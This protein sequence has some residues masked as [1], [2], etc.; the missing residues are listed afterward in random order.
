MKKTN[1]L[2]LTLIVAFACG[3]EIRAAAESP[4]QSPVAAV[5]AFLAKPAAERGELADQPFAKQPLSRADAEAIRA[6][7]TRDHAEQIRATR[8][9]EVADRKLKI[10]DLEMPFTLKTFGE[11]P[12]G[13]RSLYIS[14]H[15]G[16]NAPARVN[17]RQWS[18]Q[19]KLYEL[20]EGVYIAPRAPTNTWNLWHE[21]HVDQFFDRLIEDLIVLEEVDPNRVYL[22]GYSAGGDGVFQLAPRMADRLAAASMMAGHPNETQ[23]QG[24][25]NIGFALFMGGKDSAYGRND[26]AREWEKKLADLKAA[27]PTGYKHFVKIFPDKGHW[28]DREDAIG[29]PWMAKLTRNPLPQKVVWRQDDV[30]HGRFYWLAVDDDQRRP[31]SLVT[32]TVDGQRIDLTAENVDKL[33]VRLADGLV[34]LDQPVKITAGERVLFE[35]VV[36]RTAATLTKTLAERG[37]PASVFAGEVEVTGVAAP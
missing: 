14:M 5:E 23:P 19:Q 4:E 2:S 17:D 34:D 29:I 37:D 33:R 9:Q 30:T 18:N 31:G 3:T 32:A 28:M 1:S 7:L 22:L 12:E 35:G 27:D 6:R 24:L 20:E 8:A 13:G 15:G 21:P 36:P 25:R 16:G 26:V 10:G 11:K